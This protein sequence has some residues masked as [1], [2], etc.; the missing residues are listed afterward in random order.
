MTTYFLGLAKIFFFDHDLIADALVS[1]NNTIFRNREDCFNDLL[2]HL[3]MF[4]DKSGIDVPD[5]TVR[6]FGNKG[7]LKW[8]VYFSLFKIKSEDELSEFMFDLTNSD[9]CNGDYRCHFDI[10][11]LEIEGQ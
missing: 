9:C 8:E 10:T 11:E 6:R 7:A 4:L 3:P 2:E 1:P 5:W